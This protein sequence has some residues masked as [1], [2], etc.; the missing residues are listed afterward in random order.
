MKNKNNKVKV[1]VRTI[2]TK[3]ANEKEKAELEAAILICE[4]HG[5]KVV[6]KSDLVLCSQF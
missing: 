5:L 1:K 2:V 6:E 4:K 3:V